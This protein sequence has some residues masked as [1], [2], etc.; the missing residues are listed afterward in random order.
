MTDPRQLIVTA[1]VAVLA[2][3]GY[4]AL[5]DTSRAPAAP[6]ARTPGGVL[7]PYMRF[8]GT[9]NVTMHPDRGTISFSVHGTGA[10]LTDAQSAASRAMNLLI[11]KM[12]SD[13]VARSD[14]RTDGANGCQCGQNGEYTADQSL[15]VTVR[16]L[17]KS[18][19]LLA[20]GAATGAQSDYGVD[21]SI[22]NQHHA[23]DAALRSAIADA[24]SKADAAAAAAGLHVSGVVSVDESQQQPY[25]DRELTLAPAKAVAVPAVPIRRGTQK[26]SADVTVVFSY[27]A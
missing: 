27:S 22:G 3:A 2:I 17:S 19:R 18:G 25:Y 5:H 15:T 13:G 7:Q 11:A 1:A 4:Q 16:N 23:Y 8:T 6:A 12:R 24:R 9:G 20:D 10:T 26:V 14:M 21:F